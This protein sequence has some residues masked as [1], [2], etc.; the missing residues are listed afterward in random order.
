MTVAV[1]PPRCCTRCCSHAR[2][3]P[4]LRADAPLTC[5][6]TVGLTAFEPSRNREV[7]GRSGLDDR[8]RSTCCSDHRRT[9]YSPAVRTAL[10]PLLYQTL[11]SL[12]SLLVAQVRGEAQRGRAFRLRRRSPQRTR[13][14]S[15]DDPTSRSRSCPRPQT[16]SA[17]STPAAIGTGGL[18][19]LASALQTWLS[20]PRHS[21]IQIR[22]ENLMPDVVTPPTP[23]T[24]D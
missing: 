16:P 7:H 21:R 12:L 1:R 23:R 15:W 6:F 2:G 17:P 5:R 9:P 18:T 11:E 3:R 24:S 10:H 4:A 14:R 8:P 22:R 13:S 19:L 20:Q